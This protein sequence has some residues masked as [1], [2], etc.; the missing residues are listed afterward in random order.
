VIIGAN[1]TLY[2][3]TFAGGNANGLD[4]AGVVFN[5]RPPAHTTERAFSPWKE[6]VL[7]TFAGGGDGANPDGDLLFDHAGNIYGTASCFSGTCRG[8]VYELTPTGSGWTESILYAFLGG[9]D[10]YY[11]AG[12]V[13]FDNAGTLYGVT[14]SGG[15]GFLGTVFSLT[16]S[17]DGWSETVLHNFQSQNGG[18]FPSAGLIFDLSG[19]LY[20]TTASGPQG[21]GTV[22]EM[23]RSLGAWSFGQLYSFYCSG[24]NCEGP[25]A[26]LFLDSAG[27]LL[28]T[29]F[30]GG[31]Y[32]RGNV[33]RL[34]PQGAGW[35]YRSLH[36]FTGGSD[37]AYPTSRVLEDA[38]GNLFG[39]AGNGGT[40]NDG[41]I[42]EITP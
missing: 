17:D 22:F 16:P 4:G 14:N 35:T 38:D 20:G 25:E 21:G 11:P 28:G 5:L 3:T 6:T 12:G 41:V 32:K 40:Y 15:M 18:A 27:D 39:V 23:S 10:G 29:T 19:N 36:D 33:F 26:S 7:H 24:S 1:G 2:G 37:G 34:T 30:E 8:T 13:A 42:W 31:A 9:N